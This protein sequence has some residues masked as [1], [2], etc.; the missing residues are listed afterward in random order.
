MHNLLAVLS[1]ITNDI[2]KFEILY[3]YSLLAEVREVRLNDSRILIPYYHKYPYFPFKE[4]RGSYIK[5]RMS[6]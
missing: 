4:N 3:K 5:L 6:P 2:I 1:P